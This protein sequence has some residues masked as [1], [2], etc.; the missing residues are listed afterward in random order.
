MS[1]ELTKTPFRAEISIEPEIGSTVL[2]LTYTDPEQ[3]ERSLNIGIAP[4]LGSN[5]FRFRIGAHDLL[6]CDMEQLKRTEFT[7]DFVLWPF[8]NRVRGKRYTYQGHEYSL[9]DVERHDEDTVRKGGHDTLIHGLVLDRAWQ[10]TQ[11]VS[12][13]DSVSVTTYVDMNSQSPHYAGYPF[14]SQL[15]LTYTLTAQG[16]SIVYHIQN[17]GDKDLPFG[18]A[19]HPYFL[20]PSGKQH[21]LVSL[22]GDNVMEADIDLLPT[23]RLLD[24]NTAM[25]EMFNL[26]KPTLVANLKLDHVYTRLH[27]GVPTIITHQREGIQLSI[28]SSDDFTHAVIYTGGDSDAPFLCVEHQTCATDAINLH[29]QG[30]KHSAMAHLLEVHPG[31]TATGALHYTVDLLNNSSR[32]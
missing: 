11:P 6:Y 30:P 14:D 28:S 18:F 15:S 4:E 21:T 12:N 8:P 32:R 23:G 17:Q 24:I 7:G 26:H 29:N 10:Y 31:E 22:P 5:L 27:A 25:Y 20:T 19:L 9:Q 1:A 16:I 3:P 13:P 2:S